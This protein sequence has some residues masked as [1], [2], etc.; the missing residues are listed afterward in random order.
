M[1]ACFL[2]ALMG[3]PEETVEACSASYSVDAWLLKTCLALV[4]FMLNAMLQ[5]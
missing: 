4:S 3:R 5:Q 1:E 2:L